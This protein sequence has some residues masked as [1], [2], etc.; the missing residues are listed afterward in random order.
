[1]KK[2]KKSPDNSIFGSTQATDVY[3]QDPMYETLRIPTDRLAPLE[4]EDILLKPHKNTARPSDVP[5]SSD[6]YEEEDIEDFFE[7]ESAEQQNELPKVKLFGKTEKRAMF[8]L[9]NEYIQQVQE[10]RNRDWRKKQKPLPLSHIKPLGID[11]QFVPKQY[12]KSLSVSNSPPQ[13][14]NQKF[15]FWLTGDFIPP[16]REK[17]ITS[18]YTTPTKPK[19]KAVLPQITRISPTRK[20]SPTRH[21]PKK[22]PKVRA[23]TS[24]QTR[25]A[26]PELEAPACPPLDLSKVDIKDQFDN[27]EEVSDG[28]LGIIPYE[29]DPFNK[30]MDPN[31][32]NSDSYSFESFDTF[33]YIDNSDPEQPKKIVH[34]HHQHRSRHGFHKNSD[35]RSI[36][37]S[38]DSE[39]S[40]RSNASLPQLT[41]AHDETKTHKRSHKPKIKD[42]G[43]MMSDNSSDEKTD[44]SSE[45]EGDEMIFSDQFHLQDGTGNKV[46]PKT[47]S[48]RSKNENSD[49]SSASYPRVNTP[50]QTNKIKNESPTRKSSKYND[51][52]HNSD[53]E[54]YS[55]DFAK[56][57]KQIDNPKNT[58]S[59]TQKQKN[60]SNQQNLD[61]SN[62]F[63]EYG[64]HSSDSDHSYNH[65]YD[66]SYSDKQETT[67]RSNVSTTKDQSDKIP[68]KKHEHKHRHHK[69]KSHKTTHTHKTG[70]KL[71]SKNEEQRKERSDKRNADDNIKS[72]SRK[73]DKQGK[74]NE[75][76]S[77]EE[78]ISGFRGSLQ[79]KE[80]NRETDNKQKINDMSKEKTLELTNS[81][82]DI[83]INDETINSR[84][85]RHTM[86]SNHNKNNENSESSETVLSRDGKTRNITEKIKQTHKN[87]A[88]DTIDNNDSGSFGE[89]NNSNNL[90]YN[91][92]T[93]TQHLNKDKENTDTENC[94]SADSRTYET[95]NEKN[96]KEND[97]SP[98][99][100]TIQSQEHEK[101]NERKTYG[102]SKYQLSVNSESGNESQTSSPDSRD[103][104]SK[105]GKSDTEYK[106][107]RKE[108]G[109]INDG[110]D[111][112]YDELPNGSPISLIK[113]TKTSPRYIKPNKA[114]P[115]QINNNRIASPSSPS[116]ESETEEEKYSYVQT[117]NDDGT[118]SVDESRIKRKQKPIEANSNTTYNPNA[119]PIK[120]GRSN[121]NASMSI[122]A[123]RKM[124]NLMPR[125]VAS[126][127]PRI[128]NL[129]VSP[130]QLRRQFLDSTNI[131][132]RGEA[133]SPSLRQHGMNDIQFD[134][135]SRT[136]LEG[137][138]PVISF[139]GMASLAHVNSMM[140]RKSA[141]A[142]DQPKKS[143]RK[144]GP[145]SIRQLK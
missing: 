25:N 61:S 32:S 93:K 40:A 33:G 114:S 116:Q 34:H 65:S 123:E 63:N 104:P 17:K 69:S 29:K 90:N 135:I 31:L 92:S 52:R 15:P 73:K 13:K 26:S 140:E 83:I 50:K 55:S 23:K 14:K 129:V 110:K 79:K 70:K 45:L 97:E 126:Q 100:K 48:S 84:E 122:E 82:P 42:R 39:Y 56:E 77:D 88:H 137:D 16:E 66:Y 8:T 144:I 59:K 53:N 4:T 130:Q 85:P 136:Y 95:T 27:V 35:D 75:I 60:H 115:K 72:S 38:S 118:I 2:A 6:Y 105:Y 71:E 7:E 142:R 108:K 128:F 89:E 74:S 24:A 138:Q 57:A 5:S 36:P 80:R 46:T 54:S 98:K 145:R 124:K 132:D 134:E 1:M 43:I 121:F 131:D 9:Q 127:P 133:I 51:N 47:K 11:K 91:K 120:L 143:L 141:T 103:T 99:S 139:S 37:F 112:S 76:D 64:S 21:K 109:S 87:Y 101:H 20:N 119:S 67:P 125:E 62:S 44:S 78:I 86:K 28:D 102:S 68:N 81:D 22:L 106:S 94:K 49:S 3:I 111:A 117:I 30:L 58:K 18:S 12:M 19:G 10:V 107:T 96:G 41:M 113:K